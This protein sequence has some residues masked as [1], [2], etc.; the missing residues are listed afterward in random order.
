[1][2]RWVCPEG[3]WE[4][5]LGE[6]EERTWPQLDVTNLALIL[7]RRLH[8]RGTFPAVRTI[9]VSRSGDERVVD[10]GVID[11]THELLEVLA[12]VAAPLRMQRHESRDITIRVPPSN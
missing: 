3:A 8:R 11:A 4:C 1:M 10:F 2:P 12:E 5:A 9:A 7:S 6:Y